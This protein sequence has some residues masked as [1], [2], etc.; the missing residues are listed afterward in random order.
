MKRLCSILVLLLLLAAA[1]SALAAPPAL[2][3]A[4]YEEAPYQFLD[5]DGN[6]VGL[7]VELF[8]AVAERAGY[9]AEYRVYPTLRGCVEAVTSGEVDLVLGMPNATN[10]ELSET[11]EL[12]A[13]PLV[14]AGNAAF[15]NRSDKGSGHFLAG[16][17]YYATEKVI[18][19]SLGADRYIISDRAYSLIRLLAE[20]KLDA[21]VLDKAVLDYALAGEYR[22]LNVT[23]TID[24]LDTV[25]YTVAC[26]QGNT[27]LLRA[28]NT[29]ILDLRI[30]GNYNDIM[31]HWIEADPET[32]WLAVLKW[33]IAIVGV[34]LAIFLV[35]L[36]INRRIRRL[37]EQQLLEKTRAMRDTN[38]QLADRVKQLQFEGELRGKLIK[39]ARNAMVMVD[40]D[41]NILLMNQSAKR[42]AGYPAKADGTRVNELSCFKEA[43]ELV[44]EDI[45]TPGFSVDNRLISIQ[46]EG[47][48]PSDFRLNIHQIVESGQITGALLTLENVTQEQRMVRA[49][50]EKEKN[51]ALNRMIAGITHE[52]RNPLMSIRTYASLISQKMDDASFR[53]SFSEFVPREADRIN[54]LIESLVSYARPARGIKTQVDLGS[55]VEECAYL[56]GVARR[57]LPIEVVM[58]AAKAVIIHANPDQIKQVIINIMIN[59]IEAMED[60][61]AKA[62]AQADPLKLTISV[63]SAGGRASLTIE[64]NGVGMSQSARQ[65]CT[66]LFY[67]TKEQG[68]GLGL[69]L[70]AQFIQENGGWLE[71]YSK[72]G[73]Y[74]RFVIYFPS[75]TPPSDQ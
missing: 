74:T 59:G 72:E 39:N 21:A 2:T 37:L 63:K 4:I 38:A 64:D 33:V 56:S 15:A 47:K 68:T 30:S 42:M 48:S 11:A 75:A 27:A 35:N 51:Y 5:G 73:E 8:D 29:A 43:L 41:G 62:G 12:Y 28:L 66:N 40:R 19:Y 70:S 24:Y 55:L 44:P 14:I 22:D 45:F 20:N 25:K 7:L 31:S 16:Y 46:P 10:Y 18:V 67:T 3:V 61:M 50:Y 58:H 34:L 53:A 69:A 1:S 32:K 26:P 17:N 71:I 9:R 54:D 49:A 60:K 65:Q 23:I 52:I 6:A 13:S 57:K 36:V